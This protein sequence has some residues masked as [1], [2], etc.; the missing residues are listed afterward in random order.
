MG[1]KGNE[2]SIDYINALENAKVDYAEKYNK[3]VSMG[4]EPAVASH[5]ALHADSVVDPETKEPIPDSMGVIREIKTNT[6]GNKYIQAG[7]AVEKDLKPGA[8]RVVQIKMAKEEIA[9]DVSAVTKTVV[10]GY[11]GQKQINNIQENIEKYGP[12]GLYMDKGALAYYKG[13]AR[14]RNPRE[15]GWWGIVDA[16]L[17][18]NGYTEGLSQSRPNSVSLMTG[19]DNDGNTIPNERGTMKIDAEIVRAMNYP[20][21]ETA[22]YANKLLEDTMRQGKGQSVWDQ[23]ENL[24]VHLPKTTPPIVEQK[25]PTTIEDILSGRK[26]PPIGGPDQPATPHRPEY[27]PFPWFEKPNT[28]IDWENSQWT[29]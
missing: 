11:Y 19:V 2:K 10:G 1:I 23:L 12:R 28:G 9:N 14:G 17:K 15:G 3:Y 21:F 16:Q 24:W 8:H 18:A 29:N 26:S 4:Y 27:N 20:S 13:I 7:Q 22:S 5:Y 25:S 6:T